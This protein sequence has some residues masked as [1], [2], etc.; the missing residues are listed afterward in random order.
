MVTYYYKKIMSKFRITISQIKQY[1][2]TKN[3]SWRNR[4]F[5]SNLSMMRCYAIHIINQY[6]P[7]Y[8]L[9]KVEMDS[10]LYIAFTDAIERFDVEQST[11]NVDQALFLNIKSKIVKEAVRNI[12]RNCL[13]KKMLESLKNERYFV[14]LPEW[15]KLEKV[16]SIYDYIEA[17]C[18]PIL[19]SFI[20]M[21]LKGYSV[22]TIALL[23]DTTSAKVNSKL[24]S[25][26]GIIKRSGIQV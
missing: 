8:K 10:I 24:Y 19:K 17:H 4:V 3:I 13:D 20:R 2:I 12:K 15:I 11:Y 22:K 1:K 6:F 14:E 26:Y 18:D 25:L 16:D 7:Y 9:P 21:K 5:L 23:H